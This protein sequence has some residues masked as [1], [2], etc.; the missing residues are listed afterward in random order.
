[1]SSWKLGNPC[2]MRACMTRCSRR[3]RRRE[4]QTT[5]SSPPCTET[6]P[7]SDSLSHYNVRVLVHMAWPF[8]DLS[9]AGNYSNHALWIQLFSLTSGEH[10]R[11]FSADVR[12]LAKVTLL[13]K[14]GHDIVHL[15]PCSGR[16]TIVGQRG[17][18]RSWK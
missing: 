10:V 8:S 17:E 3:W 9:N 11:I 6:L 1:M 16:I 18:P 7:R 12:A 4:A 15:F 14:N 2:W 13:N 5:S